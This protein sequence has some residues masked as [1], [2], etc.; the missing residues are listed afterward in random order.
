MKN[1]EDS[2]SAAEMEDW[3][4][5]RVIGLNDETPEKW[6]K[7]SNRAPLEEIGEGT[8]VRVQ[9]LADRRVHDEDTRGLQ[10]LSRREER[11]RHPHEPWRQENRDVT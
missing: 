5:S 8:A 9:G 6:N 4:V 1:R 10:L 7:N 11:Q 3:T 2:P